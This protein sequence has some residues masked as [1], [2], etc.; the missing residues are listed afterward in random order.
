MVVGSFLNLL[1]NIRIDFKYTSN[2]KVTVSSTDATWANGI[3]SRIE[4][5]FK[6][7]RL[8][9]SS[10]VEDTFSKLFVAIATWFSVSLALTY[11]TVNAY[12]R[13]GFALDLGVTFWGIFIFGGVIVGGWLFY[14]FLGWLF[15]KYE[16]GETLQ[17]RLR[18]WIWSLLV[19]SGIITMIIDKLMSL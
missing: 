3:S 1:V 7:K 19:S 4:D 8:G 14:F 18:K 5:A 9:Y 10:L 13:Y 2:S 17:K 12:N 11:L 15:P 6:R 16:F